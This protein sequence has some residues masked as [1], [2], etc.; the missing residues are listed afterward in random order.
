MATTV[1]SLRVRPVG[2]DHRLVISGAGPA[3]GAT[4]GADRADGGDPAPGRPHLSP[5]HPRGDG[6]RHAP[7]L[8]LPDSG[9]RL[10]RN[11]AD[12]E[13][14]LQAIEARGIIPRSPGGPRRSTRAAINP[15]QPWR[16]GA[17]ISISPA[18]KFTS[19]DFAG[20]RPRTESC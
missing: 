6:P 11:T 19:A 18:L 1:G 10:R 7:G 5:G 3:G 17:V 8:A 14:T 16:H 4:P 15:L 9:R 12:V 2:G 20:Q 13:A